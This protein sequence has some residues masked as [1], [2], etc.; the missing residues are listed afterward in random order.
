MKYKGIAAVS[1]VVMVG[2]FSGCASTT[3]DVVINVAEGAERNME[4]RQAERV[5][6]MRLP[7]KDVHMN[8]EDVSAGVIN[9]LFN[10]LFTFD[11]V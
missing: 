6:N 7:H 5:R 11:E 2:C 3:R 1:L 9:G 8:S 10:S 4:R